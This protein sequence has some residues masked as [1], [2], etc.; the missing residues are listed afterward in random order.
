MADTLTTNLS[1]T[2]P[3]VGASSDTWGTKIN[4]DLDALDALFSTGPV[5]LLTKGGTGASTAA[6]ARTNLGLAIGS[7]V[8]AWDADLDAIA[9]LSGTSGLLKKT[10]ANTWTLDTNTYQVTDAELTALAGLVS[11]ADRLPYFTGSGAASLAVFTAAGRALVDDVDAAAQRTTLGLGTSATLNVGTAANQVVQLDGSAKLPA[12]D[13]SQLTNI[14]RGAA[15]LGTITTT[16]GTTQ[17]LSGLVLTGYKV[18]R[19]VFRGVSAGASGAFSIGSFSPGSWSNSTQQAGGF[20]DIDLASGDAVALLSGYNGAGLPAAWL[21][22]TGNTGIT[23]ASTSVTVTS[24]TTFDLG[25]ITV[26]AW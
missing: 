11:A 6:A 7:N 4:S 18:L 26:I 20:V 23:N 21:G 24:G 13:G 9:A 1:L 14:P 5:L 10:G 8:Q 17:T 22:A 15:S 16:S 19:L 12:V 2:K 3:E 25:S